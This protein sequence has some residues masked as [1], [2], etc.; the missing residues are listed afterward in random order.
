LGIP[1]IWRNEEGTEEILVGSIE[2]LYNEIEKSIKKL[3]SKRNP[4][5]GSEVGNISKKTMIY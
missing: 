3:V 2:E 5:K 1:T 4:F